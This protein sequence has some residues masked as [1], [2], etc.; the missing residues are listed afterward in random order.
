MVFTHACCF[1]H[2]HITP[3][4]VTTT[5]DCLNHYNMSWLDHIVHVEYVLPAIL[6]TPMVTRISLAGIKCHMRVI[7]K[8]LLLFCN[9]KQHP[10]L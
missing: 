7:S 5:T 6:L 4:L 1:C 10:I 3:W 9:S 8:V 2:I